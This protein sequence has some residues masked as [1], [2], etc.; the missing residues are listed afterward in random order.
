MQENRTQIYANRLSLLIQAETI[1][2]KG[3][4]DKSK[5]YHF[6]ELLREMFPNLFAVCRFEDFDGS[7]L[8]HWKGKT[9]RDPIMLMNHHDVVEATGNWKYPPFSGTVAE[10]KIWGRGTLDTKGGLWAMLQAAE[11]LAETGFVPDRD[12]YFLSACTE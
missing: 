2:G 3:Q 10:G 4:T 9:D 11:E 6:H 7:F 12:T 5:F 8:L 1:S